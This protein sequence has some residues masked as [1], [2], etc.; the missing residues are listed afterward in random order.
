MFIILC[1]KIFI[2]IFDWPGPIADRMPLFIISFQFQHIPL[3]K[4]AGNFICTLPVSPGA[5]LEGAL[6]LRKA[7]F[8]S[9]SLKVMKGIDSIFHTA[10]FQ[11]RKKIVVTYHEISFKRWGDKEVLELYRCPDFTDGIKT[12]FF[13]PSGAYNAIRPLGPSESRRPPSRS[14]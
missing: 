12:S 7:A 14:F 6:H 4:T 11:I 3:E 1:R 13:L 2:S 10:L 8:V 9:P 5:I